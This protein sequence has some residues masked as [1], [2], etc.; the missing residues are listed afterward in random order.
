M[1]FC[2]KFNNS[3]SWENLNNSNFWSVSV[4]ETIIL[5]SYYYIIYV[6][7]VKCFTPLAK[8]D[9]QFLYKKLSKGFGTL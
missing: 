9:P 2:K 4:Q 3:N 7:I 5:C 1:I 8:N 6:F